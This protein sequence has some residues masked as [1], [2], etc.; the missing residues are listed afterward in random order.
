MKEEG[1]VKLYEGSSVISYSYNVPKNLTKFKEEYEKWIIN[2]G[3]DL[4]KVKF[5]TAI[6]FLNMSPLHDEK[7][8]K[9][10]WFKSI[11]LLTNVN[12]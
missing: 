2:Q 3:F 8:G 9:M 4:D 11:E 12:K 7:F 10:L 1:S 5:I 6:I